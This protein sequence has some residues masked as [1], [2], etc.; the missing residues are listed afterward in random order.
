MMKSPATKSKSAPNRTITVA[1]LSPV[2]CVGDLAIRPSIATIECTMVPLVP[3]DVLLLVPLLENQM[4]HVPFQLA[5]NAKMLYSASLRNRQSSSLTMN[6]INIP[7]NPKPQSFTPWT[8]SASGSIF[9]LNAT[10][11]L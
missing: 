6:R 2:L 11:A 4:T 8:T 7:T 3:N 10:N 1:L 5:I 9:L